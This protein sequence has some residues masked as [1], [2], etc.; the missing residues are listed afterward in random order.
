MADVLLSICI[1]T[2]NRAKSLDET[3]GSIVAQKAF[4]NSN[5]IEIIIADNCS[6]DNTQQVSEKYTNQF[7]D[8]IKY[9]RN[10]KN[11]GSYLNQKTALDASSGTILK[12]HNDNLDMIE[13]SLSDI[14]QLIKNNIKDKPIIFCTNGNA[15]NKSELIFCKDMNEFVSNV[16]YFSTW[17]GGLFIWKSEYKNLDNPFRHGD[18][19]LPQVDI[20]LRLLAK[21]RKAVVYNKKFSRVLATE[22]KSGY[23]VAEIFGQN[24]IS[25]HKPYID[26]GLLDRNI[27]KREKFRLLYKHI[28][29]C[30]FDF[31]KE[32][33]YKKTGYLKYLV[34]YKKDWF[35]YFSFLMFPLIFIKSVAKKTI[36][37][38][39]RRG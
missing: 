37:N 36:K 16:S 20:L 27:F 39:F 9:I 10:E 34:D 23:N 2:Y 33:N 15:K 19:M 21:Q 18:L 1:P 38:L 28:I 7:S 29:P 4:L 12:L 14:L 30:Y 22:K 5:E 11:I 35:F 26:T 24:Y 17:I 3:I 25:L 6:T 13:D 31:A 32:F 8:K